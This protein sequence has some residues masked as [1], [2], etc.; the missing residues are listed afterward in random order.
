[1]VNQL[2]PGD[3]D[4]TLDPEQRTV[5]L[6]LHGGINRQNADA[7]SFI[8]S[9]ADYAGYVDNLLTSMPD[10]VVSIVAPSSFLFLGY[11][12]RDWN[13]RM[14][15]LGLWRDRVD[16]NETMSWAIEHKPSDYDARFWRNYA[17]ELI[18]AS[19]D[20]WVAEMDRGR[21]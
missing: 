18:E 13:L 3:D 7:G 10:S 6:K 2:A 15:L 8:I 17:I 12:L 4:G 11:G 1:M 5:I 14:F 16:G 20:E 19:L 9:D 21:A